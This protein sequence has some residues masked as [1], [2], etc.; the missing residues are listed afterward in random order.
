MTGLYVAWC[1]LRTLHHQSKCCRGDDSTHQQHQAHGN[2]GK[3]WRVKE[4]SNV[5]GGETLI[6]MYNF[7]FVQGK[8]TLYMEYTL[9]TIKHIQCSGKNA[10]LTKADLA[11]VHPGED[12]KGCK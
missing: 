7:F 3:Y 12:N 9:I 6:A 2:D 4:S 11:G 10:T 5:R 1:S 8:K